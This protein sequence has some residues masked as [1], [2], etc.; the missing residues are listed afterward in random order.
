M[1][2]F[3]HV[4]H[5]VLSK[6]DYVTQAGTSVKRDFV[7]APSQMFE[8]WVRREEVLA[9]FRQVCSECPVLSRDE[10]ARLEGARRFG[11][12]TGF[13]RQWQYAT[14]DLT[15]SLE[16]QPVGPLWSRIERES[17]IAH[18]DGTFKPANFQHLVGGYAAG[19][20]G[21][22]WSQVLALDMLS[23]FE[24]A[25]LDPRAGARYRDT[26]LSQGGQDEE[27]AMVERFL[28]RKPS[29]DAFFREVTGKR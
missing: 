20:Y 29:S 17:P 10:I 4:L 27:M 12:A 2:E 24:P 21:Y 25:L 13:E 1:H 9:L 16:P 5:G 14:L 7:E 15:L 18:L 28:G 23:G 6:A 22:M 26:I 19:Y 11:R 3:G 8:E